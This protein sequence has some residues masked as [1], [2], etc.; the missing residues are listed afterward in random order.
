MDK[1][2]M[3]K[4]P[5]ARLSGAALDWAVA[6]CEEITLQWPDRGQLFVYSVA[7]GHPYNPTINGGI[8]VPIIERE[9]IGTNIKREAVNL[10]HSGLTMLEDG[11]VAGIGYRVTRG[12]AIH[13]AKGATMLEAAMRCYVISKRGSEVEVPYVLV[14]DYQENANG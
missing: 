11:W 4:M 14:A 2:A 1:S 3:R 12:G 6:Q 13:V 5:V 7:F 9:K 10:E 8:A